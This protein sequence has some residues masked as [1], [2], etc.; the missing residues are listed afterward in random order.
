MV[1]EM[2]NSMPAGE[3]D[4]GMLEYINLLLAKLF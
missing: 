3:D 1:K 4:C 2:I